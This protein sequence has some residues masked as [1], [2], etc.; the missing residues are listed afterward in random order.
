MPFFRF[1]GVVALIVLGICTAAPAT[2]L[3]TLSAENWDEYAPRGKEVDCIF[4]DYVLRSDQL[5]AV[6]AQ[7][8][9]TRNANMTVRD[10]GA[11]IIDLTRRDRPND[12]LSAFYPLAGRVSF[13]PPAAVHALGATAIKIEAGDRQVQLGSMTLAFQAA[14]KPGQPE[15]TLRYMLAD[16][17]PYL[18][19]E[20]VFHNTE[21]KELVVELS[22]SI[23]ADRTFQFGV[24]QL[25][26]LFWAHDDWFRQAYGVVAD[27]YDISFEGQRGVT[28]K[29]NQDGQ[30]RVTL[31]PGASYRL[32]RKLIPGS[33]LLAVRATA[34]ELAGLAQHDSQIS[35]RDP[36]GA[37]TNAKVSV[38][39]G[40]NVYGSGRTGRDGR[41]DVVLPKGEFQVTAEAIGR[42]AKTVSFNSA[43]AGDLT[44][45]LA[46]C[47]YVV[48]EITGADGGPIPC[49]VAFHG[50]DGTKDPFFGPDSATAGIN[51]LRYSQ[52]GHFRQE[53]GPGKYEVIVSCGPE[54]DAIFTELEVTAGQETPLRES[55]QRVVDSRGWVSSDF[56]SHSSPSGDNTTSQR[57]RVLNLL[58]ENIEFAPCTEHNR[59]DTYVPHLQALGVER[60]MATCT[61]MELT[62]GPLP[63]NHQNAFPLIYKPRTQ[64]GGAPV[65]DID[66]VV[67][68][69]RLALWDNNSDKLVQGNHPNIVQIIGD[70]NTDGKPDG[71]FEKMFGFMDVIEVHPP[72][73]I[74]VPPT[75]AQGQS[76]PNNP[77]F[78]WM[79]MLN[80]GYRITGVVNTDAHYNFHGSGWLRNYIR[81]ETDDPAQ[82]KTMDLVH[83]A[84]RG[85][86]VMS[87]GPFMTV[88]FQAAGTGQQSTGGPGDDVSAPDGKGELRVRVQCSNWLDVN[89][90][91]VFLNGRPAE[92]LNFTR[93]ENADRFGNGVVKFDATLPLELKGDT[94]IIVAAGG[95]GLQV[96]RVMGPSSGKTMPITVA[97]PIFVDVDGDGFQPNGDLLDVPL[98]IDRPEQ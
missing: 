77:I 72:E 80:L 79:Q 27:K 70:K 65:T 83:A 92:S 35:V 60:L 66:P 97:N 81:S 39:Q 33:D 69:E 41:L 74:L 64:D 19:V 85:N 6:I 28:I 68:I 22:D 73:T 67:Q 90:V 24:D 23:R 17:E 49:K 71:G 63:V 76:L 61:G 98:P 48:A 1:A 86:V 7:P 15:T 34:N 55:L 89:R 20:T 87:N 5:I 37:V 3:V 18:L 45:D 38:A 84:E 2:E 43:D 78:N 95:E 31:A 9:P 42:A 54:Y 29:Y 14:P 82:L 56:H 36:A 32:L 30:S 21:E 12:Q 8:S 96:G 47:G 88:E 57:G 10:V 13:S 62:G 94:H 75:S 91:Q 25:T 4:G 11:A 51:N 40:K 46:S 59:I 16:G 53:L 50:R 26:N 52:N 93:R 58:C 44:I